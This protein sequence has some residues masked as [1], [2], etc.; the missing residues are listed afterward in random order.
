MKWM[1]SE[2]YNNSLNSFKEK[3]QNDF[4]LNLLVKIVA[5]IDINLICKFLEDINEKSK[6]KII[7]NTINKN[8]LLFHWLLE[9][10]FQSFMIKE[11]NFDENK[12]KPGF[13]IHPIDEKSS[14]KKIILTEKEKIVQIYNS[15]KKLI[16]DITES[17]IYQKL[18]YIFSWGKY[19]YELR[20]N[21]NN[22]QNV[23]YF[24]INLLD[25]LDNLIKK[26]SFSLNEFNELLYHYFKLNLIYIFMY[27]LFIYL[28][29][30]EMLI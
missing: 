28:V 29:G 4:V 8:N 3:E 24:I 7:L 27:I 13:N 26:S 19:Y 2:L 23:K 1:I 15:T 11:T 17:N 16:L 14:D 21:K 20:T 12:F 6:N 5:K 18:D 9:T 22:F 25:N 30:N 10:S